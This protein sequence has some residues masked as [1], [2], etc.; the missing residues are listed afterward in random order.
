MKTTQSIL[1]IFFMLQVVVAGALFLQQ[2]SNA[3]I[4]PD[5]KL[6]EFDA[7][8]V[9]R[10]VIEDADGS[11]TLSKSDTGWQLP[12]YSVT[13]P[14]DKAESVLDNLASAKT[15]WAVANRKESHEQLEVA[16]QKFNRKL[17]LYEADNQVAEL[18]VGTSP[19]LRRSHVRLAD[20]ND[21]YSVALN[22]YEL[23][24][25][26]A[27][28]F[29]TSL[30][31]LADVKSVQL[32]DHTIESVEDGWKVTTPDGETPEPES[33][34]VDKLVNRLKSLRV[35]DVVADSD[36]DISN[37]S[38]T[39][40]LVKNDNDEFTYR[41]YQT[42]DNYLLKRSDQ[43]VVF[44]VNK[45][46]YEAIAAPDLLTLV[47]SPEPAEGGSPNETDQK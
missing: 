29:D 15:G 38:A 45:T 36:T 34:N 35:T 17:A 44:K 4:R 11:V 43:D 10:M 42:D 41:F 24:T 22:D 28:W 32:Q 33:S 3:S 21:V 1:A 20:D 23:S 47:K 19:G 9:T 12:D 7:S 31:S 40:V 39:E 26:R 5:G 6:L 14:A 13:V 30:L 46:D 18:Y 2:R 25:D 27:Q 37:D 16:E 8:S